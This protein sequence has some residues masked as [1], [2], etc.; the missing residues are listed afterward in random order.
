MTNQDDLN[1]ALGL[2]RKAKNVFKAFEDIEK[3]ITVYATVQST[4]AELQAKTDQMQ[5]KLASLPAEYSEAKSVHDQE[6]GKMK[7]ILASAREDLNAGIEQ[8]DRERRS[9]KASHAAELER[10]SSTLKDAVRKN[11]D[12]I[13]AMNKELSD[14][15]AIHMKSMTKLTKEEEAK[16]S[17]LSAL[18]GEI[19]ALKKRFA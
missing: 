18:Q 8:L 2:A 11:S 3:L 12:S 6:M 17:A 5:E 15:T 7:A 9:A 19:D 1:D 13:A 14:A 16:R 10:M 4:L